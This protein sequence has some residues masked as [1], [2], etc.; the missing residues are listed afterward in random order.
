[1]TKRG[2]PC[3]RTAGRCLADRGADVLYCRCGVGS[4]FSLLLQYW[5]PAARNMGAYCCRFVTAALVSDAT[6]SLPQLA[7]LQLVGYWF[8]FAAL[9]RWLHVL[10]Q[11][12]SLD[13]RS[14]PSHAALHRVNGGCADSLPRLQSISIS[15]HNGMLPLRALSCGQWVLFFVR[16]LRSAGPLP[17]FYAHALRCLAL[18]G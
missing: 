3:W 15:V 4:L 10:G 6:G 12:E 9:L 18:L 7:L 14:A 5:F 8:L 17:L 13:G 16:R 2:S 1:M 11:P